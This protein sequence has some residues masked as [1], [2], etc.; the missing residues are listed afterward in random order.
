[1][2]RSYEY[3]CSTPTLFSA[4]RPG[5]QESTT[6]ADVVISKS[7][8]TTALSDCRPHSLLRSEAKCEVVARIPG[9]ASGIM[10][11]FE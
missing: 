4:S 1:M 3:K 9:Q 2:M 10:C 7:Q 11:C 6:E 5:F 8:G